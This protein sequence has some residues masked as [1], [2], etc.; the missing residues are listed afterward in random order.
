[1][2]IKDYMNKDVISVD[3]DTSIRVAQST[4]EG[5]GFRCLPVLEDDRLVGI[6]T[7]D[8]VK[9]II[10]SSKRSE[11][12][13][14]LENM[15]VKDVM[16]RTVITVD[17]NTTVEDAIALEQEHQVGALPVVIGS[18]QLVGI[19]TTTDLYR[20]T[21]ESFGFGTGGAR[22]RIYECSKAG[23]PFGEV[24]DIIQKRGIKIQSMFNV[25][26]PGTGREYCVIHVACD[27]VNELLGELNINGYDAEP[28]P[29]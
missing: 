19:I 6:V 21:L 22:I 12:D 23:R 7:L 10:I 24:F 5:L 16:E 29:L 15:T 9:E 13:C 27:D 1:M 25:V 26:P 18:N 8:K 20:I 17:P 14:L 2:Y 28:D 11:V 3:Q 4:M